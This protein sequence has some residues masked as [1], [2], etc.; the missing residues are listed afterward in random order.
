MAQG[1]RADG[2]KFRSIGWST[3]EPVNG[4]VTVTYKFSLNGL[5][6]M[7]QWQ[8]TSSTGEVVPLDSKAKMVALHAW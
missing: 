7:A 8:Y 5:N 1:F 6:Q 2:T 3:N 4:P